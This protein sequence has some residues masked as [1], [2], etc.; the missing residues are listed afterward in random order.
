M[1]SAAPPDPKTDEAFDPGAYWETRLSKNF[2][3]RGVGDIGLPNSYNKCLYSIRGY[4]FKL[5]V[6]GLVGL[7]DAAVLDIGSGT[8]FYIQQWQN[9]GVTSL[10]GCDL[11]STAVTNLTG[12]YPGVKFQ[13]LDI[14]TPQLPVLGEFDA[15]SCFDVLFHIVDD[16]K[17][18]RAITNIASLVKSGGYFIYSDNFMKSQAR[19]EHQS[20][21]TEEAILAALR[22]NSFE[23]A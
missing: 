13:Q 9:V 14:S 22:Q 17:Y 19:I 7:K 21:R 2:N 18:N 23:V 10:Q 4:A 15:V 11:T 6:R 5:A 3:L 8:G 20:G 16:E 12:L 1:P